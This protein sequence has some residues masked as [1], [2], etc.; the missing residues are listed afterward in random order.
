ILI[1]G[2]RPAL[3]DIGLGALADAHGRW[4]LVDRRMLGADSLEVYWATSGA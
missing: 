1:G 4:R 3:G 2:G